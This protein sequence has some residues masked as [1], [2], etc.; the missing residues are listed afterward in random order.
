MDIHLDIEETRGC[1]VATRNQ[2][3][4]ALPALA[5]FIAIH[6]P[7]HIERCGQIRAITFKKTAKLLVTY[8]E[9]SECSNGRARTQDGSRPRLCMTPFLYDTGAP[10]RP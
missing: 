7:E 8:P 9:K 4:A 2:R 10:T 6:S 1:N 5:H 3:P